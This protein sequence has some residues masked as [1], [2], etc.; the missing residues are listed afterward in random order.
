MVGVVLCGGCGLLLVLLA[1]RAHPPGPGRP[2]HPARP[3]GPSTTPR[4]PPTA[5]PPNPSPTAEPPQTRRTRAGP[6]PASSVAAVPS[7]AV[8]DSATPATARRGVR[9]GLALA[10]LCAAA[11]AGSAA[12]HSADLRRGPVPALAER[13][14]MVNVEVSVNGD[15]RL[16]RPRANGASTGEPTVLVPAV[17]RELSP[18]G[19]DARPGARSPARVGVPAACAREPSALRTPVLLVVSPRDDGP[20]DAAPGRP[21]TPGGERSPHGPHAEPSPD[22]T[23]GAHRSDGAEPGGDEGDS[24][25]TAAGPWR[26]LLPSTRLR[27][28]G[29][30][31]P[32]TGHSGGRPVAAVLRVRDA[33]PPRRTAAPST[34]QRAAGSLRTGLRDATASLGGDA[35]GLLP[36]LVVGDTSRLPDALRDAFRA[37]DMVHLLAVSGANLSILLV[38][39]IGPAGIAHRSERGGLAPGLGI[40]LRH[41]ALA[42]SLLIL[43]FVLVC[44]P[45]P[46]VLRAAA[47]GAITLLAIGTGRRRSLIPALAGAVLLLLLFDPWLARDFGFLLSVLATGSLLTI[48]P[49][50]AA[51]LRRRGVPGRVAEALAAAA[52][53]QLVCAPVVVVLAAHVSLV[54]VP[55]NLLAEFLVAPATVLG[56]ATLATGVWAPTVANWLAWLASWPT[57]AIAAIARAGARLPGAEIGWPSGWTG[58]LWLALLLG[59]LLWVAGLLRLP[60]RPLLCACCALL[61]A[62]AL[63]RP[64]PLVRPLLGWPPPGWRMVA[65][66]VGQGDAL[67][68]ATGERN[69]AVLVDAGPD[70]ETVDRCLRILDVTSIPLLLLTHFH[71]D[72]VG[73]L[74][75]AL[76]GRS[77]GAVQTTGLE[78]PPGQARAVRQTAR[79]AGVPVRPVAA[80]ERRR[81]AELS[82]RVLW[83]PPD[84]AARGANDAS[85]T[86]LVR[87]GGLT[88]LLAGDLEPPAQR[89]LLGAHPHLGTVDVLKLPHHGSPHQDPAFLGRLRPR[90]AL[91]S[92]GEDNPY[93]HPAPRVLHTLREAGALVARTD[94]NGALAVIPREE[95]AGGRTPGGGAAGED[96]RERA[97]AVVVERGSPR[98]GGSTT[99]PPP[100]ARPAAHRHRRRHRAE[101]SPPRVPG[102]VPSGRGGGRPTLRRRAPAG[103]TGPHGG[104][105]PRLAHAQRLCHR[106][107]HEPRPQAQAQ[108]RPQLQDQIRDRVQGRSWRALAKATVDVHDARRHEASAGYPATLVRRPLSGDPRQAGPGGP[109]LATGQRDGRAHAPSAPPP[110]GGRAAVP[111]RATVRPAEERHRRGR[112]TPPH[113]H[114][115]EPAIRVGHP[116]RG[117]K[118]TDVTRSGHRSGGL[119]SGPSVRPP[120]LPPKA[121]G[122]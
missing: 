116:A 115:V 34:L 35:R 38:L 12:L 22:G 7:W 43:A 119:V 50:W 64:A 101:L 92:V 55:C 5:P 47:C 104:A 121:A 17:V 111:N 95:R 40:P 72:H 1:A 39:L 27:V 3:V 6:E 100:Q 108:A 29:Q 77:V 14:A 10:L 41:T 33:G 99:A 49:R 83:P 66:D 105:A 73:G 103:H 68:L 11:A 63:F 20:P 42:G 36:A 4:H 19:C 48:A 109:S 71:A 76:R 45:E 117:R 24:A 61:L 82:W 31:A 113:P 91:V 57:D 37:T 16:V 89:R 90:L 18:L 13:Y 69:T 15:P 67:V 84:L 46:S 8:G 21:D 59:G 81:A 53:A 74:S 86:L 58:A 98:G 112:C 54:A 25:G 88:A 60:H 97:P 28:T 78:E 114:G 120:P 93:G 118:P 85:V 102:P 56:F 65:C 107:F 110:P 32:T 9:L 75:G 79:A 106:R 44:R 96:T 52:A 51:V 70:P 26:G 122:P 2:G 94:Q 87:T 80:G 30:L 62:V 23:D